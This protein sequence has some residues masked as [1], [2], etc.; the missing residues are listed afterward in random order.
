MRSQSLSFSKSLSYVHAVIKD[1]FFLLNKGAGFKLVKAST[2]FFASSS[3]ISNNNDGI[4]AFDRCPAICAPITPAPNTAHFL[5][6]I[7]IYSPLLIIVVI[8]IPVPTHM[9]ASPID[10]SCCSMTFNNVVIILVPEI[11]NG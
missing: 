5:I 2:P 10:L 6:S 9:V 4:P 11:P 7:D 8:P 3:L 1:T